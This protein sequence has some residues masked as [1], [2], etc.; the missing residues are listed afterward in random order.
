MLDTEERDAAIG[1]IEVALQ[2]WLEGI[3]ADAE[4]AL[5][6]IRCT[7]QPDTALARAVAELP[8]AA[9]ILRSIRDEFEMSTHADA[10][11][12]VAKLGCGE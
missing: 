2:A 12:A 3:K 10:I 5:R 7:E 4:E 11:E 8:D 6:A 1:S 9:N